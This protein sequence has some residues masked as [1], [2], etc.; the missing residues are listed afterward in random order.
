[1]LR[2]RSHGVGAA[3]AKG[4]FT[5]VELLVVITII[6]ILIALLLPAVQAAR[7]AARRA[8]CINHL[9][10]M[11]LGFHNYHDSFGVFPDGGKNECTSPVAPWVD[12][13]SRCTAPGGGNAPGCCGPLNRGEWSWPY[14]ILPYLEL[15]SVRELP[16]DSLIYQTP[17]ATY[18]C[19]TRRPIRLYGNVAKI[20]YAGCA[21]SS[22]SDGILVSR[23]SRTVTVADIRD[24]TSCT[25]M[26]GEKQLAVDKFGS[27]YD[28]NEAYV[29]PGWD[30]EIYRRG[31]PSFPPGH[32]SLHPSYTNAD[33]Y[34]G[35]EY[36]GSSH[37]SVFN[38]AFADGAVRSLGY[39]IDLEVFHRLCMR[40]D[41]LP[42]T[43]P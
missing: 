16:G 9:K 36:F 35:S 21:G 43:V 33:P 19:P 38:A 40:A 6:G 8:E 41:N 34:V 15:Q 32:D 2:K 28:D 13:A 3:L 11:S 31:S 7:E 42:V 37:P 20:D 24:G 26:L 22:G 1:M 27:T 18:Y 25:I 5:L 30:S 4:G 10:Q 29:A 12:A 39:N 17:V 14:Q 23:A